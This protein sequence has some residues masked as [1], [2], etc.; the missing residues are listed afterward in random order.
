[1]WLLQVHIIKTGWYRKVKKFSVENFKGFQDKI[2]FDL[3]SPSNYSFHSEIIENNCVTTGII[4]GINSS[5][6]FLAG[7]GF[8]LLEGSDTLNAS[9]RSESPIFRVKYV[10][11]NSILTNNVQTGCLR[12]LLIL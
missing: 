11:N 8:T 4:Y 3:G 1:M 6:D 9:I 2:T 5:F 10:N 12:N 7:D